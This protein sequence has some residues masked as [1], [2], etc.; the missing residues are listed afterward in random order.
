M[1]AMFNLRSTLVRTAFIC[2][3]ILPPTALHA[4][5]ECRVVKPGDGCVTT[6]DADGTHLVQKK[7][8]Q[9]ISNHVLVTDTE[10]DA[11]DYAEFEF[12]MVR[13]TALPSIEIM[14]ENRESLA[15]TFNMVR[16]Q[17]DGAM[18]DIHFG[19][20]RAAMKDT[21]VDM[22]ATKAAVVTVKGSKAHGSGFLV[23]PNGYL[24]TNAHVIFGTGDK[25]SVRFLNG[26]EK[27]AELVKID[28][29][30]D[31]ALLKVDCHNCR[32]LAM[33]NSDNV[34][35]GDAVVAVGTPLDLKN[36]GMVTT[37]RVKGRHAINGIGR[38]FDFFESSILT[39]PGNSGGP[40]LNQQRQVIGVNS[41]SN[42][43]ML[44]KY[45]QRTGKVLADKL[46]GGASPINEVKRFID[47]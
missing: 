26:V 44:A 16:P 30:R 31:L 25:P 15:A 8:P 32:Y 21:S 28:N 45:Y 34:T 36:E 7:F 2:S 6:W 1:S 24:I 11:H 29:L 3:F 38:G 43:M 13:T 27:R 46:A 12:G 47:R 20:N 9:V 22:A 19:Q 10:T 33:G 39:A 14:E 17:W 35:A 42:F 5:E 40:L 18:K 4:Q 41:L 23:S 37:G